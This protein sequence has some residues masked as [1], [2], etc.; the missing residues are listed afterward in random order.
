MPNQA[1]FDK[2]LLWISDHEEALNMS[3]WVSE[4][5][6]GTVACL[7][8]HTA[9][10]NGWEVCMDGRY[11]YKGKAMSTPS[12]VAQRILDLT[13]GQA[14][15]MFAA[16]PTAMEDHAPKTAEELSARWK[17]MLTTTQ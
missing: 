15:M 3:M 16:G 1:E 17:Y 12:A 6:C 2:V 5:A 9:L 14:D 13:E 10:L 11:L 4:D 7:A 8:G